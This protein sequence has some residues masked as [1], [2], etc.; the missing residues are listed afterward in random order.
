[1]W[2]ARIGATLPAQSP[3]DENCFHTPHRAKDHMIVTSNM[4]FYEGID[5]RSEPYIQGETSRALIY[6][7]VL[8]VSILDVT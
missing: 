4:F 1:M 7:L 3:E 2:E 8:S 5:L 6:N